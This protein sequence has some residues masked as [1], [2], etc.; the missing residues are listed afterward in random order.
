MLR[1]YKKYP[2]TL[3]RIYNPQQ[4][5]EMWTQ[6][7]K[8]A[9]EA[10]SNPQVQAVAVGVMGALAW[11]VLDIHDVHTQQQIAEADRIAENQRHAEEMA[12]REKDRAV[13][14]QH[15]TEEMTM[16]EKELAQNSNK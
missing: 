12:T 4:Q 15:H 14:N 8:I 2:E 13:E 5:R 16:R 9:Q 3:H 7:S 1:F 11:K 6:A 10:A